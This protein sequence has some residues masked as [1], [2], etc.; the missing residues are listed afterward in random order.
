MKPLVV[1]K[2]GDL[3][4]QPRQLN[5]VLSLKSVILSLECYFIKFIDTISL[6]IF[7]FFVLV[8]VFTAF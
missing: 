8:I 4:L 6:L 2:I 3:S 5:A 7:T 1:P